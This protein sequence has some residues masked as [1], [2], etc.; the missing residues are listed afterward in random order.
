MKKP[1]NCGRGVAVSLAD[2]ILAIGKALVAWKEGRIMRGRF[3]LLS[4]RFSRNEVKS[5]A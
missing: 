5:V 3:G 2:I 1:R 4:E